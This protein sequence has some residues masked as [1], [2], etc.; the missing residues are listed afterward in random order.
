M[1]Q[2]RQASIAI[3]ANQRASPKTYGQAITPETA[4]TTPV[5]PERISNGNFETTS[6][7]ALAVIP[8]KIATILVA[9]VT[10]LWERISMMTIEWTKMILEIN[11][12]THRS[13]M[14]T[15]PEA[16]TIATTAPLT[17]DSAILPNTLNASSLADTI[18]ESANKDLK[19]DIE[20]SDL[21]SEHVHDSDAIHEL[22]SISI[23]TLMRA[24][25]IQQPWLLKPTI[26]KKLAFLS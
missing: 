2:R 1:D 6:K 16:N 24:R 20:G 7:V 15:A 25:S 9:V 21:D 18:P 12:A 14:M 10:A 26:T 19:T 13:T 5:L 3:Y 23:W 11:I 17:D 22:L 4:R 8:R